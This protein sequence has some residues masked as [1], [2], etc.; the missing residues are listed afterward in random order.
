M[1]ALWVGILLAVAASV[2]LNG[3]YLLQHAGSAQSVAVS[4]RRPVT[5][6]RSLLRSPLWAA[7]AVAGMTGWA[8]HIGA[9]SRAPISIVQAFVAGGLA[10]TLPLVA[11]SGRR[12]TPSERSGA[13]LMVVGLVLLSLGLHATSDA[14]PVPA[15][16]LAVYAVA[17]ALLAVALAVA[18]RGP[19]RPSA[20]G[21]AGGVLYGVADLAV[22]A[23]T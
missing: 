10:L 15:S 7:G 18:A 17:G 21:V 23:L 20:L 11:L 8:L 2:L 13:V 19:I 3:S 5:T 4:L 9:L 1:S 22:K 12:S 6:L 16:G 14:G